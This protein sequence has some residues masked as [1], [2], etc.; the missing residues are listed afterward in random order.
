VPSGGAPLCGQRDP[1]IAT[2]VMG[3][4]AHALLSVWHGKA[5]QPR[6]PDSAS[7]DSEH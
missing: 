2:G 6:L 4:H 7:S 1:V 3:Q 5:K